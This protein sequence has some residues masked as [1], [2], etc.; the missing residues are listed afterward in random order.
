MKRFY[1][2]VTIGNDNAILLDGRLLKTP[3]KADLKLPSRALAQAIAE[4]WGGQGDTVDA[5]AMILTKLANTAI[6]RVASQ[7]AAIERELVGYG[8]A[9]LLS[10]RADDIA[11]AL[12]QAAGW[13]PIVDW[14]RQTLGAPL[15]VTTGV[16]HIAQP[17]ETLAALGRAISRLDDWSLSALQSLTTVTGSL[18]L[19]LAV[20]AGR[21]TAAEAF[22]LSRLD[23][24]YQAEKWGADH[25]AQTRAEGLA[26]E[27]EMAGKFI[28][29]AR[30]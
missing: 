8:G 18:T 13:D 2:A 1:R 22:A 24:D 9:D 11:L 15:A 12:R 20:T 27:A 4:E 6:D 3:A 14:A 23:E 30:S 10:Y 19:A 21:L 25:E 5:H 26:R 17:P 7:R 29:L 28:A 16:T